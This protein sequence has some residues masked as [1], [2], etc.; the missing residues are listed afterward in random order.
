MSGSG[1]DVGTM[2]GS[3]SDFG[4]AKFFEQPYFLK[5]W[6]QIVQSRTFLPLDATNK[7]LSCNSNMD[8]DAPVMVLKILF[9]VHGVADPTIT[10]DGSDSGLQFIN[11]KQSGSPWTQVYLDH[12]KVNPHVF[13]EKDVCA[14]YLKKYGKTK[15]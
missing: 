6:Q 9:D 4:E 7:N 5:K 15:I 8:M 1:S 13:L 14:L 12:D 11:K 10:E 3:G 2:S